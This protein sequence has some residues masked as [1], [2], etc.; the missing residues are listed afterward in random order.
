VVRPDNAAFTVAQGVAFPLLFFLTVMRAHPFH[1][2]RHLGREEGFTL[3]EILIACAIIGIGLVPVSWALTMAIQ[4]VETGRQQSTAVFLAQQRM[5]QVKEVALIPTEPPLLN[6]T[7]A[8]FPAEPYGTFAEAPRFRRLVTLSPP[9][10]FEHH[11]R[12]CESRQGHKSRRRRVLSADHRSR[13][14]D[15]H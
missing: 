2:R 12:R 11:R 5:D 3:I 1:L 15:H 13:R 6:V 9:P 14:L 7:A 10:V 4:G 8:A